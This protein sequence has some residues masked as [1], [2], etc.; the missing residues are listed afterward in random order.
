MKVSKYVDACV[1]WMDHRAIPDNL[2]KVDCMQLLEAR[3]ISSSSP[4]PLLPSFPPLPPPLSLS[5][6]SP[7]PLPSLSPPSPLPL[8]SLSPPPSLS[9]S[10][11]L[12]L[13]STQEERRERRRRRRRAVGHVG[14][15]D[16]DE[17][18]YSATSCSWQ[19]I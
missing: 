5:P 3:Y 17:V 12:P 13:W 16:C 2:S 1:L 19:I 6:P 14:Q 10:P 8:P 4:L 9:L 18:F 7:L 15:D 11:S